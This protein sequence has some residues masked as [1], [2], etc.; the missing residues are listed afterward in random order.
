MYPSK[1]IIGEGLFWNRFGWH[2]P[3]IYIAA[4]YA[5]IPYNAILETEI[6]PAEKDTLAAV[7]KVMEE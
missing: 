2:A 3:V 1:N 4:K 7:H 5:P 6:I